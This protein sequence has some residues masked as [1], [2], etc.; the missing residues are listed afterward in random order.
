MQCKISSW[1]TLYCLQCAYKQHKTQSICDLKLWRQDKYWWSDSVGYK[2]FGLLPFNLLDL[3]PSAW[4]LFSWQKNLRFPACLCPINTFLFLALEDK[5]KPGCSLF[6][7]LSIPLL[8]VAWVSL[9]WIYAKTAFQL[10]LV[11]DLQNC[12]FI[13]LR[14][15]QKKY[16]L[17]IRLNL[18]ATMIRNR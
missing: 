17:A 6:S 10:S 5:W 8:L 12:I 1:E 13:I 9:A 7:S 15:Q 18:N 2:N 16:W 11:R 14:Q 3:W 4:S